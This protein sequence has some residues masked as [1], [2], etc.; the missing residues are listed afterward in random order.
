MRTVCSSLRGSG[1]RGTIRPNMV[2]FITFKLVCKIRVTFE[3]T[4][5]RTK[6]GI[7]LKTLASVGL[8]QAHPNDMVHFKNNV[9]VRK[10][11]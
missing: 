6:Y 4:Y 5:V 2:Q 7:P 3:R 8:A 10:E 11:G 9:H 1:Y